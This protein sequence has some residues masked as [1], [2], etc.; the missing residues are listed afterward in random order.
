[1]FI[2]FPE[3]YLRSFIIDYMRNKILEKA[4]DLFLTYGFKSVTM[5]DIADA[6]GIS[7]KTIYAHFE[8]KTALV[9]DVSFYMFEIISHGIN[10]ICD[11]KKNP[12]EELY[13]IKSF[14]MH[15]LKDE[16][17]SPQYQLQ[18]YYPK[19]FET[20]KKKQFEVMNA[21]ITENL[22]RGI[23]QGFYRKTID[24]DFVTKIYFNGIMGLKN[25]EFFSPK[26]YAMNSLMEMY[27][28]YHVR[29]IATTKGLETL[30]AILSS[31]HEK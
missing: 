13:E 21:C 8:T 25:P 24:V 29:A 18:K 22:N 26:H 9:K 27:L 12:I 11:L 20:L 10:C 31:Q 1:M 4:A 3:L 28:E 17:S 19:I 15:H 16:K 5:D 23:E 2:K 14:V 30:N 7:K 6:L